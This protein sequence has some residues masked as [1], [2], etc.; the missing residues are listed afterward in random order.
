MTQKQHARAK[1]LLEKFH[2]GK[3]TPEELALLDEWYE[4]LGDDTSDILPAAES[5]AY[6]EMFLENMRSSLPKRKIFTLGRVLAAACL[7]L[8]IGTATLWIQKEHQA[9]RQPSNPVMVVNNGPGGIKKVTLPDNSEVWLNANA[10]MRW[11]EDLKKKERHL[12]LIGE[13]YFDI[14]SD[15]SRPFIIHTRDVAIRVLGTAFCVEAYPKEKMTRV[16]LLHGKVQVETPAGNTVL[17]PGFAATYSKQNALLAVAETDTTMAVNW[18]DGGFAVSGL[19][20]STAV[21]R[22]CEL[23][24]YTVH[25]KNEEDIHKNISVALPPQ[26]FEK[27]LGDLCYMNH[28]KFTISGKLVIIT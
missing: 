13:G 6:R 22:L 5:T 26:S 17:E 25:W 20:F 8:A 28:K 4:R 9:P 19:T 23:H 2:A 7:L 24:G 12:T 1:A 10:S 16:S 27:M 18:K 21:T 11:M 3:C 15:A 14:Q